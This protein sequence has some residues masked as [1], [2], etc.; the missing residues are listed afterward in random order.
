MNSGPLE[1]QSVLL[2]TEPSLQTPHLSL[3][4]PTLAYEPVTSLTSHQSSEKVERTNSSLKTSL[5]GAGEVAQRIR[6]LTVL[7]EVLSSIPFNH[8]VDHNHL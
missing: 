8:M 5:V 3:V 4:S 2:T 6:A 7:P 1:E